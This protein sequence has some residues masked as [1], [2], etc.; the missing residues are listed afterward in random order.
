VVISRGVRSSFLLLASLSLG[1]C[2][3]IVGDPGAGSDG[4]SDVLCD[5]PS[6]QP[7]RRL[8]DEQYTN[9]LRDLFGPS[10]GDTMVSVSIF[11]ATVIEN[12]FAGDADANIVSTAE[13]Q[14]IEDNA[15]R[16]AT[17]LLENADATLPQ[18]VPC[19]DGDTSDAAIEGCADE[20]I[21]GFGLR[22]FRRPLTSGER[23]IARGLFDEVRA[24]QGA[25]AAWAAVMQFLLQAPALLYR[26]EPGVGT[27]R[28][29]ALGDYEMASRLSFFFWNTMPDDALFDAA[30]RGEL[31]TRAEV[32]AQARRMIDDPRTLETLA[33]FHRDWLR[34]YRLADARKDDPAFTDEVRAAML[35]EPAEFVR[36]VFDERGGTYEALMTASD[37]PR[38]PALAGIYGESNDERRGIFTLASVASAHARESSSHPIERG[39]FFR[40]DLLCTPIPALPGDVD[41]SGPLESSAGLPTAR[42]RLAPLLERSDCRTCHTMFNPIGLAFENYD[43]VGRWRDSENGT[44]IDASADIEVGDVSGHVEGAGEL[45]DLVGSSAIGRDCY[46]QQ[47]LRFALGRALGPADACNRAALEDAFEASDGDIRE[48]LVATT[49]LDAFMYRAREVSP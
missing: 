41:T 3:G 27:S 32:E 30:A 29:V 37:F 45:L 20:F 38:A 28:L 44:V 6:E 2:Q 34:A 31:R 35:A 13:S 33:Q 24:L 4:P 18:L 8:S 7:L 46:S 48:L 47:W 15:E 11:P 9:V 40:R 42:E 14:R 49:Q 19:V 26:T 43:A 17:H 5:T 39:A 22:A 36:W 21:D 23:A 12:G 10:L 25:R 16:L 1:A